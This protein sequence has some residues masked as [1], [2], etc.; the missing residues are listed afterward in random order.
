MANAVRTRSAQSVQEARVRARQ[1][2]KRLVILVVAV[3]V[4]VN[5]ARSVLPTLGVKTPLTGRPTSGAT[6]G[7]KTMPPATAEV[8]GVKVLGSGAPIV[9]LDPGMVRPDMPVTIVGSGFDPG[10]KIDIL[11]TKGSGK[12]AKTTPLTTATGDRYG[13][14][15]T[16]LKFPAQGPNAG[17]QNSEITAQQRG[18]KTKKVAKAQAQMAAG[19]AGV[20]KLSAVVGKPGDTVTLSVSG[21]SPY[22][23]L[24]VYWGRISG[25]PNETLKT[26]STGSVQKVPL[27]VGVSAV[28]TTSLVIVGQKSGAAASLPFQVLKLYPSIALKPYAV[29]AMN[30]IGFTGKGFMPNERVLIRL[31]SAS[32]APILVAQTDGAGTF[33]SGGFIVPYQLKGA[34]RI[35]FT[36]ELSRATVNSSFTVLPYMPMVRTSTY[37]GSPGTIISFYATGFGANEAVHVYAAKGKGAK[38]ELV[39]AFRV[40]ATGSARAGGRYTVPGDAGDAVLFTLVGQRSGGSAT[41][42]FK[43]D[44]SAGPVDVAPQ[45]PYALPP[46][47]QN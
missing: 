27:K 26:D 2:W 45:P 35:V 12:K 4:V 36:G 14:F 18:G 33:R 1:N 30:P 29:K 13:A 10:A 19:A 6:T 5:L 34:Q 15:Y 40:D 3:F 42:T 38:R 21:F 11:M 16:T 31:N 32:G 8:N 28:G 25:T 46:D 47:L 43:V 37:G 9:T 23:E 7:A 24:S 17:G 39:A 41:V 44:N 20:A 22:E